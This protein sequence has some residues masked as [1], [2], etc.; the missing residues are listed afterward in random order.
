[1]FKNNRIYTFLYWVIAGIIIFLFSYLIVK[2]IP[3]YQ[4]IIGFT[5]Q[6]LSPFI[7][8][9]L[10]AYILYPII[11]KLHDYKIPK[12][13][14][15]LSIYLV[16][17]G[18]SAYLAYRLY[19]EM[20][21]QLR[22]LNEHIPQFLTMYEE[23]IYQLYESTSFLPETIHDKMDQ[24]INQTEIKLS[25][26]IENIVGNITMLFDMIIFI[27]VLPVLVFYILKD[28][29]K[30]GQYV[31]SFIPLKHQIAVKH[32]VQGIDNSLGNYIKGQLYVCLFVGFV[33]YVTFEFLNIDYSLLLAIIMGLTNIIPY[34]GPIIGALPAVAIAITISNKMV[35]FVVIAVFIIQLIESNLISPYIVGRSINIHPIAIIFA[36]L[37][38][39]ELGG[40]IG[41]ILAVPILTVVREVVKRLVSLRQEH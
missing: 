2:L 15:V 34:F 19:P 20:I 10:I 25:K 39:G 26:V 14:A 38:G 29:E 21:H 23:I 3:F 30:I 24:I 11:K 35:L 27:T 9:C 16:F 28:H 8:A 32:I 6:V 7:V 33:T 5:W 17:F 36:L 18:G 37:V 1:M 31:M 4:A 13:I 12:S 41:M 22:D 40:I